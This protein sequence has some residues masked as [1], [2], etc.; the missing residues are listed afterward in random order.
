MGPY[1]GL[2]E[3]GQGQIGGGAWYLTNGGTPAQQAAAWDFMKWFNSTPQQVQWAT[4]GSGLP[5]VQS[6]VDS[7]ELQESWDS[8]LA[9]Q[10]SR[11]AYDVLLGVDTDFPGPLIGDY[12]TTRE[13]IRESYERVLL[14]DGD[15]EA[16]IDQADTAITSAAEEYED[17]VGG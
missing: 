4:Q 14:G 16:A 6:A 13:V 2:D 1:P 15:V 9:G 12:T 10:W 17:T 8:S 7:P 11:I 3:P 5:A